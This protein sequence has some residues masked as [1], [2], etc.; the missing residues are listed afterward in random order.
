[1]FQ[2]AVWLFLLV[3]I[4]VPLVVALAAGCTSDLRQPLG[5]MIV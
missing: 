1:V 2:I 4:G 3:L 5:R